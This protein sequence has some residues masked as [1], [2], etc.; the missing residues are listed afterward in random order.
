MHASKLWL[1]HI[2]PLTSLARRFVAK[3]S[4]PFQV[5]WPFTLRLWS[6]LAGALIRYCHLL[7]HSY[8]D[9]KRINALTLGH[10][11][12]GIA[13]ALKEAGSI[14]VEMKTLENALTGVAQIQ[15]NTEGAVG[16]MMMDAKLFYA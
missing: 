2:G 16:L 12:H 6:H 1:H 10:A 11:E 15:G 13:G 14:C 7:H 8:I 5:P 9:I 4:M 3:A